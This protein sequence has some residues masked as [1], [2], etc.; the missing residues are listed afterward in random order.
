MEELKTLEL[1]LKGGALLSK[2]DDLV[3]FDYEIK[4][5]IKLAIYETEKEENLERIVYT[6]EQ[7]EKKDFLRYFLIEFENEK[8]RQKVFNHMTSYFPWS[9]AVGYDPMSENK[10]LIS[11][12]F[13]LSKKKNEEFLPREDDLSYRGLFYND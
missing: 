9:Y 3:L 2:Y 10:L 13:P 5:L 12:K 11:Q 8:I 1:P 6:I 7:S 4:K